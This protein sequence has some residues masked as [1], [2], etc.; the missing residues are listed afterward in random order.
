[1]RAKGELRRRA[2][3]RAG[4]RSCPRSSR[5]SA[6]TSTSSGLR[7]ARRRSASDGRTD[8]RRRQLQLH[9]RSTRPRT[10]PRR[11]PSLDALGLPRPERVDVEF[12]RW[13]GEE[14]ALPGGGPADQRRLQREPGLDARRAALTSPPRAGARRR[15]AI[16]GDMAEL[17]PA[18]PAY[19]EE[20]GREVAAAR[21]RRRCSRSA[22]SRAATSTGRRG[23]PLRRWAPDA[24]AA[25]AE[26][27]RARRSRATCVLVKALARGRP[28]ARRG[29]ARGGERLSRVLLAGVVA[30][31][32]SI[33]AG[34]KF[35]EFLRRKEFGQ[36]IREEGPAAPRRQAGHADDGR[37]ADP[38]RCDDR[39]P[40]ASAATRCR[41]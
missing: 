26:V 21:G 28:R 12:S 41:R 8:R 25:A 9:R 17:G 38:A 11:L 32:I 6:T 19:H 33:L 4:R 1:M 27:D 15:V 39:L 3:A 14:L 30:L 29:R 40:R 34:P 5:S 35:I 36:H 24:E 20:I 18:A 2:A 16:L 10:P 22:S 31:L 23:V 37:P 13:R 7:R